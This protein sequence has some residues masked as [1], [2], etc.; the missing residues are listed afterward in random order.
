[1][2]MRQS[3][4]AGMETIRATIANLAASQAQEHAD[5]IRPRGFGHSTEEERLA[6]A[7]AEDTAR[8]MWDSRN[9]SA[10]RAARQFINQARVN[11]AGHRG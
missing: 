11:G 1:M 7:Q 10:S 5:A 4:A 6:H 2:D 8:G 3:N 9:R